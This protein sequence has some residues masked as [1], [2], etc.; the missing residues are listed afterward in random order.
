MHRFKISPGLNIYIR[1][2]TQITEFKMYNNKAYWHYWILFYDEVKS[3]KVIYFI[4][5]RELQ[6]VF[7]YVLISDH[8]SGYFT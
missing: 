1:D 2:H 5:L 7:Q 3:D 4:S 6:P 8:I